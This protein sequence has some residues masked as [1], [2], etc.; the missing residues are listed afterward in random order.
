MF[1]GKKILAII[2]PLLSS[3]QSTLISLFIQYGAHAKVDDLSQSVLCLCNSY[4]IIFNSS[5]DNGGAISQVTDGI[6]KQ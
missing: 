4:R 1:Q 2:F 5:Y 3:S 6:D